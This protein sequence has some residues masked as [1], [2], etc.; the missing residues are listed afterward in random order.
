MIIVE[1]QFQTDKQELI[2][3]NLNNAIIQIIMKKTK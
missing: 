2:K 1:N 3:Q